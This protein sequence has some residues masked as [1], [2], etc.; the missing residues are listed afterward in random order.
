MESKIAEYEEKL[1]NSCNNVE[2]K[3]HKDVFIECLT[4]FF[5]I[6]FPADEEFT[7]VTNTPWFFH[8]TF[9]KD[10]HKIKFLI[11]FVL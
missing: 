10:C 5:Q 8:A 4:K 9:T 6:E 1:N 3:I 11:V 7:I 2:Y